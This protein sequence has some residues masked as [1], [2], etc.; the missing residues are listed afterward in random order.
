MTLHLNFSGLSIVAQI[1]MLFSLIAGI[2]V[3]VKAHPAVNNQTR[4]Y[5]RFFRIFTVNLIILTALT[6][7]SVLR[8]LST[9]SSADVIICY[10]W[11]ISALGAAVNMVFLDHAYWPNQEVHRLWALRRVIY[12]QMS[13][14]LWQTLTLALEI[15]R[16]DP[17]WFTMYGIVAP[18]LIITAC[19]VTAIVL[20]AYIDRSN[21]NGIGLLAIAGFVN[22]ASIVTNYSSA[23]TPSV[24]LIALAISA[25]TGLWTWFATGSYPSKFRL[26]TQVG[27]LVAG[28][29]ATATLF[30]KI[31][32]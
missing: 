15:F 2:T 17:E 29:V 23:F 1:I 26:F 30:V 16:I 20:K 21:V 12:W 9:P 10:T 22:F 13:A 32:G 8:Q 31:G 24:G 5:K 14:L 11:L 28:F 25:T 27:L 6:I 18:F 7:D 4:D 3:V 19:A